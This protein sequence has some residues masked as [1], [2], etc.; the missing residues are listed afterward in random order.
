MSVFEQ[1]RIG[2]Q[3][4]SWWN[5]HLEWVVQL[6]G[7]DESIGVCNVCHEEGAIFSC[8]MLEPGHV[9]PALLYT[10]AAQMTRRGLKTCTWIAR[11]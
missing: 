5:L 6:L 8:D 7:R 10:Y 9:V 3:R 2:A 11:V 1:P 4:T